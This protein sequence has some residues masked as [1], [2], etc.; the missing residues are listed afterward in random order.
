MLTAEPARFRGGIAGRLETGY[1]DPAL[2]REPP[3]RLGRRAVRQK[4]PFRRGRRRCRAQQ[5]IH[6]EAE[7][8]GGL[9]L[10]AREIAAAAAE[11]A[12]HAGREQGEADAGVIFE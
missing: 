5:R 7:A 12:A 11:L 1:H 10:L 6:I 3:P 2:A 4:Q 9:A 8:D